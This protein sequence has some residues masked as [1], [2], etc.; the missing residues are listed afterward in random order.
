M[1]L[2]YKSYSQIDTRPR[3]LSFTNPYQH[4]HTM[5]LN[6]DI[7]FWIHVH[8]YAYQQM[9][10]DR[11]HGSEIDRERSINILFYAEPWIRHHYATSNAVNPALFTLFPD[12]PFPR[13]S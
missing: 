3:N 12:D 8:R 13:M 10:V 11:H 1:P 7:R 5:R 6:P 4:T 2:H 9:W